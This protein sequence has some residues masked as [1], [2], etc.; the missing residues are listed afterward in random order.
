M[1]TDTEARQA[2]QPSR[3]AIDTIH[4]S[5]KG[6]GTQN[7]IKFISKAGIPGIGIGASTKLVNH[8][9]NDV[10]SN[11]NN[12]TELDK[13]GLTA[14]QITSVLE[15]LPRRLQYL[16]RYNDEHPIPIDTLT[17]LA[18][19]GIRWEFIRPIVDFKQWDTVKTNPFMMWGKVVRLTFPMCDGLAQQLGLPNNSPNRIKT[20]ILTSMCYLSRHHCASISKNELLTSACEWM[21]TVTR[22]EIETQ[23]AFLISAGELVD[24]HLGIVIHDCTHPYGRISTSIC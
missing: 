24:T 8:F 12:A 6:I 7:L 1:N 17:L 23:L 11:Y 3:T 14:K 2:T 21:P 18:K 20:G 5:D 16:S 19:A 13:A 22:K 10:F 9:G 4:L 15:I